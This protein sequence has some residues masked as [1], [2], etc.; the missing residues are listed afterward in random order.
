MYTMY[1]TQ[2]H[3]HIPLCCVAGAQKEGG[4]HNLTK[5]AQ[6]RHTSRHASRQTVE[7]VDRFARDHPFLWRCSPRCSYT[8]SADS[9]PFTTKLQR[10]KMCNRCR[11]QRQL[12]LQSRQSNDI[13]KENVPPG[14]SKGKAANPDSPGKSPTRVKWEHLAAHIA[15]CGVEAV[16]GIDL[17]V[18]VPAKRA[19]VC[20]GKARRALLV[21]EVL[22]CTRYKFK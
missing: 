7:T 2:C 10:S 6:P 11:D 13:N 18:E 17:I 14:G 1:A 3:P 5:F 21:T 16:E 4:W 12:Y 19:M 15:N 9:F 22:A 20:D 8:G